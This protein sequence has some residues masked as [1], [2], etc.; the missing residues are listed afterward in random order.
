MEYVFNSYST[1]S[2]NNFSKFYLLKK[3][4]NRCLQKMKQ[5]ITKI[6]TTKSRTEKK[7]NNINK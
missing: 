6:I 5:K 3:F 4:K 1:F 7:Q 2:S